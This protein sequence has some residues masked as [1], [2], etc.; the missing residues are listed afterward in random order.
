L[1]K[2]DLTGGFDGYYKSEENEYF[3]NI[4]EIQDNKTGKIYI[5][6]GGK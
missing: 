1:I 5:V 6:G 4:A 2:Y 3:Y